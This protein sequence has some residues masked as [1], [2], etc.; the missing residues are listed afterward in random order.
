MLT[1]LRKTL[2]LKLYI[3]CLHSNFEQLF[4][5]FH[6]FENYRPIRNCWK[7]ETFPFCDN[8]LSPDFL[9]ISLNLQE[10]NYHLTIHTKI[11]LSPIL[12]KS[13]KILEISPI[14]QFYLPVG[15]KLKK[16]WIILNFGLISNHQT[17]FYCDTI[18]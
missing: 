3:P 12:H 8:S 18:N 9:E 1:Q 5:T 4:S 11:S 7:K 6:S 17:C 16:S 15:T 14:A 10:K 13:S 2:Q